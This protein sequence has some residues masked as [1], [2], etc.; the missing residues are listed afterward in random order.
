LK[1]TRGR[2]RKT[3]Q[4]NNSSKKRKITKENYIIKPFHIGKNKGK[5]RKMR[6]TWK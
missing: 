1:T 6:S 2:E 4:K 5:K 3:G